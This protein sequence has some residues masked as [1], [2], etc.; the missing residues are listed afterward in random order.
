MARLAFEATRRGDDVADVGGGNG[1]YGVSLMRQ[2]RNV[3]LFDITPEM[4]ADSR[5]RAAEVEKTEGVGL[6]EATVADARN[7]PAKKHSFDTT[8]AY[9]PFYCLQDTSSRMQMLSEL[10]RVTKPSGSILIQTLNRT[11]AVRAV[12]NYWPSLVTVIDWKKFMS[13]VVMR[14]LP[15]SSATL[16]IFLT[17]HYWSTTDEVVTILKESRLSTVSVRSVDWPEPDR[18]QEGLEGS[19]QDV[20]DA[21][22]QVIWDYGAIDHLFSAGNTVIFT[23]TSD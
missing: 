21:W 13:T 18:G 4:V 8:I 7:L 12:M 14:C 10:K 15:D 3:H 5:N 11:A 17:A 19:S 2:G 1:A 9:G 23:T 6:F 20:V 16:P 22:S